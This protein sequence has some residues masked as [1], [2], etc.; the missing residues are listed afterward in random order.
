MLEG[1]PALLKNLIILDFDNT[2]VK[3]YSDEKVLRIINNEELISDILSEKRDSW[4]AVMQKGFHQM[5]SERVDI[6]RVKQVIESLELNDHFDELFKYLSTVSESC[7]VVIVS[8][9]N[10]LYLKWFIEKHSLSNIIKDYF[11]LN[12]EIDEHNFIN[13]TDCHSHNC[14][15][16][17]VS[18]CKQ[19]VIRD[20]LSDKQYNK[21]FF[22]GDGHNDFCAGRCLGQEDI[23][24]PRIGFSLH[25]MV[26]DPDRA[27]ELKCKV[28]SWK[29]GL[30]VINCL[31]SAMI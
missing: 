31:K 13:I 1:Q 4:A 25:K 3:G 7:D 30:Q 16:C 11:S 21:K 5:K 17:N 6:S 28:S 2:I 26:N 23:I 14:P 15:E 9:A 20:Y 24:L 12:A 8:G 22:V 18:Q 19:K 10:T 27:E 29:N